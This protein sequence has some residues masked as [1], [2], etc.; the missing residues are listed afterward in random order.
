MR[1]VDTTDLGIS[2]FGGGIERNTDPR[3]LG[4]KR[5]HVGR[6]ADAIGYQGELEAQADCLFQHF[7]ESWVDGRLAAACEL[8]RLHANLCAIIQNLKSLTF[9]HHVAV[10]KEL[11]RGI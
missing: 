7:L 4:Y 5:R 10:I 11:I 3:G 1:A 2:F 6:Y 8:N 9:R